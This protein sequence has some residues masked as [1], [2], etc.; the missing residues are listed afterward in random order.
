MG[1]TRI[2]IRNF[3]QTW[4]DDQNIDYQHV[5]VR[6]FNVTVSE[7]NLGISTTQTLQDAINA[8]F[9]STTEYQLIV[10]A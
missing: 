8:K 5:E 6:G 10:L 2:S 9:R 7:C 3:V 4:L 1:D